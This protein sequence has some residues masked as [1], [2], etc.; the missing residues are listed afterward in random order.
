MITN[1]SFSYFLPVCPVFQSSIIFSIYKLEIN[2]LPPDKALWSTTDALWG[3][4]PSYL[5]DLEMPAKLLCNMM[6]SN[7]CAT[8]HLLSAWWLN[9]KKWQ[10]S[11]SIS[12]SK[13]QSTKQMQSRKLHLVAAVNIIWPAVGS[14]CN[15][16]SA[17]SQSYQDSLHP[18]K[19]C[20]LTICFSK[21]FIHI[22]AKSLPDINL[23]FSITNMSSLSTSRSK[24]TPGWPLPH[25]MH[26]VSC[27]PFHF[28]GSNVKFLPPAVIS[29][30]HTKRVDP[31]NY[32]RGYNSVNHVLLTL[33]FYHSTI[34]IHVTWQIPTPKPCRSDIPL[35]SGI[36]VCNG[37]VR[38]HI[39]HLMR[40][41]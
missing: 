33:T 2:R 3:H 13:T 16:R 4:F 11:I 6:K 36:G 37:G 34:I 1:C 15:N 25:M 10:W 8:G 24:I 14:Q 30:P 26:E 38:F 41:V 40:F 32:T 18:H 20:I 9:E 27:H 22:F 7:R 39:F 21:P 19:L 12:C 31:M 23:G 28:M 5:V 29:C 35:T 17:N